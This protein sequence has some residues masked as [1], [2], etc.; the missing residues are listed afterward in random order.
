VILLS[1]AFVFMDI[2]IS[3]ESPVHG[4]L[5]LRGLFRLLRVFL[6]VRKLN[7]VRVKREVRK[8]IDVDFLS[9][10]RSPVEKV[11]DILTNLRDNMIDQDADSFL[12]KE[13]NYCITMIQSNKLYEADLLIDSNDQKS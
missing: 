4:I 7:L 3:E 8:K 1:I 12:V 2:Y 13:A 9:D 5:K 6:L 11:I 10:V